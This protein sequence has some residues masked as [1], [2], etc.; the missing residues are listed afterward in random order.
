VID[1]VADRARCAQQVENEQHRERQPESVRDEIST[2]ADSTER[3]ADALQK[4][5]AESCRPRPRRLI[6]SVTCGACV[7]PHE[8]LVG[9]VIA[10]DRVAV[11]LLRG[12]AADR[13]H[14]RTLRAKV[15]VVCVLAGGERVLLPARP[16]VRG[17]RPLPQLT[18]FL[19]CL[20]R[21]VGRVDLA[22]H[23]RPAP[24]RRP[25][26]VRVLDHLRNPGQLERRHQPVPPALTAA[27]RPFKITFA[28]RG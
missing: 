14:R 22:R 10:L 4:V 11:L 24:C 9:V 8:A 15:L 21:R 25:R 20:G 26:L 1:D 17:L 7:H 23:P 16:I 19:F 28:S 2:L 5:V 27:W 12:A 18:R 6:C 13:C 3:F